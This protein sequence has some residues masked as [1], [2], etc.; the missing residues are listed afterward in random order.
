MKKSSHHLFM[1]GKNNS[2][3]TQL[4]D[5]GTNAIYPPPQ[6]QTGERDQ[7]GFLKTSQ[8]VT[9]DAYA[10][11]E[12]TYT[13]IVKRRLL[14]WRQILQENN[15]HWP[16]R[17][18]KLKRYIRKGIPPELRGQAWLHYSGAKSKMEANGGLYYELV[19][20]AERMGTENENMDIIDRDLH[21]TFPENNRFRPDA[22]ASAEEKKN[23]PIIKSLR[24]VLLA[25][26]LYSPAIGY[27]QSLNYIAGMLLLFMTEEEA[28]W[29]FVV[30]ITEILPPNIYDVTMEGANIDQ[31][32]LMILISERHPLLWNRLSDNK[33]FW[34]CEEQESVGMPTC[35]LV[36]SHWFLTLF[37]NILPVESVL[38]VWD[39]LF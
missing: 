18:S 37:I 27:C 35:S 16:P 6:K 3:P 17:S 28:F 1:R 8:W 9:E 12:Q 33:S 22:N 14:K 13:P 31:N 10:R 36:T 11:F 30:M 5:D 32:V 21:R 25:F 24:R 7:Y 38:R 4:Y 19:D 29:T 15:D 26:S 39:C 2:Q 34:E 23:I 20:R